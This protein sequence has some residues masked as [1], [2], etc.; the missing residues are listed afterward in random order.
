M[1]LMP[2][3]DEMTAPID[4]QAMRAIDRDPRIVLAGDEDRGE[5]QRRARR[6]RKALQSLGRVGAGDIGGVGPAG[7]RRPLS[8]R[9]CAGIQLTL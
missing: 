8:L 4:R 7:A 1:P 3:I 6:G 2:G 9:A 5:G